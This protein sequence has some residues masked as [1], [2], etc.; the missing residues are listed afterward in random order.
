MRLAL[1]TVVV[2]AA[3]FTSLVA[4]MEGECDSGTCHGAT[5]AANAAFEPLLVVFAAVLIVVIARIARALLRRWM[6]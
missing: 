2:G 4:V 1:I 3:T 6:P 5:A